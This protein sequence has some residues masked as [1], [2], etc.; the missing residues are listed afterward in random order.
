MSVEESSGQWAVG[1]V[2]EV[3]V[4][5]KMM[6]G[7]GGKMKEMTWQPNEHVWSAFGTCWE[8]GYMRCEICV[9]HKAFVV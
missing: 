3:V 7:G 6:G 9:A 8:G 4:G 1:F 5:G 2:N